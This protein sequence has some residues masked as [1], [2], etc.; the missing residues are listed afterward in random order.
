MEFSAI[1]TKIMR[2]RT[3]LDEARQQGPAVFAS[4]FGAEDMVLFDLIARDFRAIEIATLDTG[5]LPPETYELMQKAMETYRC[6]V[7]IYSPQHTAVETYVRLN[8]V[9]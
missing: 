2:T 7:K 8:G 3:R 6:K 1:A 9:N 5:R 4:S